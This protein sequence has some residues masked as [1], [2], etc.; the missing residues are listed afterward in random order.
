M[1][2]VIFV[3]ALLF[4]GLIVANQ[5]RDSTVQKPMP[6]YLECQHGA[7]GPERS[8]GI[9]PK[10]HPVNATSISK[11]TK[12]RI[13]LPASNRDVNLCKTLLTASLLG[14]PTPT[15]IAWNHTFD[16]GE[17]TMAI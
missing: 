10:K 2:L 8:H 11:D 4:G 5:V 7:L 15:L 1:A 3:L 6:T 17:C 14:Y 9:G 12:L 16:Q 13:L